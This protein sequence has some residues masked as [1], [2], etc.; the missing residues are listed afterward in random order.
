MSTRRE[1]FNKLSETKKLPSPS[2]ITLKVIQ[3]CHDETTSVK[4]IAEV[5]E[6]DPAFTAEILKYANAFFLSTGKQVVSVHKAA[7]KLG[8]K[9]VVNLALGLSLLANNKNGKCR[10]FDYEK[11]W[12]ISLLQAIAAKKIAVAGT[13]FDPEEMF[14]CALLSHMGQLAIASIFPKEYGDIL[15]DF[16]SSP[17]GELDVPA[18]TDP[19]SNDKS[20]QLRRSLEKEQFGIDSSELTAELFIDWGLPTHYALAAGFHDDLN[21]VELGTGKT[22]KIAQLISLSHQFAEICFH[23]SPTRAQLNVIAKKAQKFEIAEGHFSI[24][25]DTTI[26]EWQELGEMFE[27]RTQHCQLYNEILAEKNEICEHSIC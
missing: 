8:L 27:I 6:T 20:N 24:I 4:D 1:I 2:T 25:F 13:E 5:I 21:C 19:I 3:L 14:I 16:R 17:C 11:F 12:S 15:K 7:V 26:S 10:T 23:I 9:T 22:Q 18:A